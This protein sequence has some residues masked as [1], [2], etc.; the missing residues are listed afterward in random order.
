MTK[1]FFY[2]FIFFLQNFPL[3]NQKVRR[4]A[5]GFLCAFEI[6]LPPATPSPDSSPKEAVSGEN[7]I[8]FNLLNLNLYQH[9]GSF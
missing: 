1:Y 8:E 6:P 4:A 5:S 7:L 9:E 3:D 2:L